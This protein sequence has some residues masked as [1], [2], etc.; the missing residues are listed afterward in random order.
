[1]DAQVLMC[2]DTPVHLNSSIPMR[3]SGIVVPEPG[4]A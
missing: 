1:M 4:K 2:G 3:I